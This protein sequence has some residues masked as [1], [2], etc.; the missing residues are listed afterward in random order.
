TKKSVLI[1]WKKVKGAKKYI[2]YGNKC[3]VKN[4]Y[5]K[6]KTTTKTSQIFTKVAGKKVA[7]GIYYKFIIYAVDSKGRTLSTSKTIHVATLGGKVG[8]DKKV[9]TAAKKNKVTLKKGKSFRLRARAIPASKTLKVHRHRK[10]AYET[11]NKKVAA[12]NSKGVIKAKGRGICYVY[13]YTQN[14][15]SARIKVI[16]E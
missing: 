1:K 7:K 12:V 11:S 9:T 13:A 5:R 3:G 15:I 10:M 4:K 2:I 6:L 14:G 16:V 8:N